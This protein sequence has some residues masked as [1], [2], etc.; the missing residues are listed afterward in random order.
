MLNPIVVGQVASTEVRTLL[1]TILSA[2]KA[3]KH[4]DE[5]QKAEA[6]MLEERN[7]LTKAKDLDKAITKT[8]ETQEKL[9]RALSEALDHAAKVK[10]EANVE[11]K[12][13]LS[14]A[15]R[16]ATALKD[17][18]VSL[19]MQAEKDWQAIDTLKQEA[20]EAKERMEAERAE[21]REQKQAVAALQ[22]ELSEKIAK[23]KAI[24][25]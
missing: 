24:T 6:S 1:E 13:V 10:N 23:L 18:A 14:E 19:K 4:L 2:D 17:E 12:R 20:N 9:D 21:V 16:E 25:G 3:L 11:A 22:I 5:I 7:K 8:R 15:Q